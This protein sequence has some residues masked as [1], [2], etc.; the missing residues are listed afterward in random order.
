MSEFCLLYQLWFPFKLE[1]LRVVCLYLDCLKEILPQQHSSTTGFQ[2]NRLAKDN[3]FLS[4]RGG[5]N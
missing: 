5:F 3:V 2:K 4:L 1:V